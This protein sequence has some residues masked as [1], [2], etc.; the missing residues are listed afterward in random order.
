MNEIIKALDLENQ[1]EAELALKHAIRQLYLG[2]ICHNVGSAPFKSY[3][4][5]EAGF[6]TKHQNPSDL[7][8]PGAA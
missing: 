6:S 5:C 3:L 4:L 2:L 7:I 1:E 8:G